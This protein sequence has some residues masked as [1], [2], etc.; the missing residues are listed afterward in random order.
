MQTRIKP[1]G[2][3]I[4]AALFAVLLSGC[5]MQEKEPSKEV[6]K[7]ALLFIVDISAS[8]SGKDNTQQ[9]LNE[10]AAANNRFSAIHKKSGKAVC[11]Y[12]VN[13]AKG[14]A[15]KGFETPAGEDAADDVNADYIRDTP[16]N[17]DGGGTFAAA[18]LKTAYDMVVT[19]HLD[20]DFEVNILT[21]GYFNDLDT[22]QGSQEFGDALEKIAT[23]PNVTSVNINCV[24]SERNWLS[25]ITA[26]AQN[27]GLGDKVFIKNPSQ[28]LNDNND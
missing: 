6:S 8:A 23:Q 26:I 25:R 1:L 21:D 16:E 17:K 18:G 24:S 15:L 2:I 20:Q 7:Q 27:R 10:Y 9:R 12:Y 28:T 5:F 22:D 11:S 3:A 14:A 19:Q 13:F 4:I